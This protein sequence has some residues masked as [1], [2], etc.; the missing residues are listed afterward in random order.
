M[1]WSA[2]VAADRHLKHNLFKTA[3]LSFYIWEGMP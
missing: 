2:E 1:E 3:F